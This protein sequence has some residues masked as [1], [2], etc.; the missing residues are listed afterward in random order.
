MIGL[1]FYEI[2]EEIGC[3][4]GVAF[5]GSR[6][7]TAANLGRE[8]TSPG[9][10]TASICAAAIFEPSSCGSGDKPSARRDYT[11]PVFE[12]LLPSFRLSSPAV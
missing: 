7:T 8:G 2:L 6:S 11:R 4:M 9:N 5:S 10:G 3:G 1:G 12:E